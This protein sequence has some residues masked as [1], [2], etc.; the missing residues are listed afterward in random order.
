LTASETFTALALAY[1]DHDD[2]IRQVRQA[3]T[4]SATRFLG[5]VVAT[6]ATPAP[7]LFQYAAKIRRYLDA[8]L[9]AEASQ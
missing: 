6:P 2:G 5:T 7:L 3:F 4:A 1:E 9:A 8:L